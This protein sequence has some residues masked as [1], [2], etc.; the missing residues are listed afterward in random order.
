V[1]N[2]AEVS[3]ADRWRCLDVREYRAQ[4]GLVISQVHG[5]YVDRM[6]ERGRGERAAAARAASLVLRVL[7]TEAVEAKV[8]AACSQIGLSPDWA[9]PVSARHG[10]LEQLR[11]VVDGR[12]RG[13]HNH[14]HESADVENGLQTLHA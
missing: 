5:F 12:S 4:H 9:L 2:L 10:Q 7:W 3:V 13:A 11:C 14:R 1:C 8:A 6:E